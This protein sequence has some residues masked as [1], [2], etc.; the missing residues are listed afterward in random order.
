MNVILEILLHILL[1][2]PINS[3][4]RF[5]CLSAELLGNQLIKMSESKVTHALNFRYLWITTAAGMPVSITDQS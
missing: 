1:N 4:F 5:S 2:T 3:H